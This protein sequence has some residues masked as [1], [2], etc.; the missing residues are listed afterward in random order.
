[1]RMDF[2]ACL[3]TLF[4]HTRLCGSVSEKPNESQHERNSGI[5]QADT[6]PAIALAGSDIARKFAEQATNLLSQEGFT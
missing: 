3:D 1:M 6:N 5:S 2:Y 4:E